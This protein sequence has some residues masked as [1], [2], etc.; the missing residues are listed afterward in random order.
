MDKLKL[1]IIFTIK[2]E[3]HHQSQ[4]VITTFGIA[5]PALKATYSLC[6]LYDDKPHTTINDYEFDKLNDN[7]PDW[8]ANRGIVTKVRCGDNDYEAFFAENNSQYRCGFGYAGHVYKTEVTK[9]E[10]EAMKDC[11][12]K[13]KI[14]AEFDRQE[15]E[16]LAGIAKTRPEWNRENVSKWLADD[17]YSNQVDPECLIKYFNNRDKQKIGAVNAMKLI[18]AIANHY[19]YSYEAGGLIKR[20]AVDG[21]DKNKITRELQFGST[22]PSSD[23]EFIDYFVR[24][25][26]GSVGKLEERMSDN[27]TREQRF[28]DDL[29]RY[30]REGTFDSA[31]LQFADEQKDLENGK[32]CQLKSD[33]EKSKTGID[34]DSLSKE[35][36]WAMA[37]QAGAKNGFSRAYC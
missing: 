20:W 34:F 6:R 25:T 4:L 2:P 32:D 10:I 26:M 29:E 8:L 17:S 1:E 11:A 23:S 33:I 12:F 37:F 24:C 9:T 19:A 35:E 21:D 5:I 31:A 15:I 3:F 28:Y 16:E 13:K 18:E 14:L 27:R 36:L 7:L 30:N 22:I